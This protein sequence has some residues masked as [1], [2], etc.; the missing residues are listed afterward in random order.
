MR[1][2]GAQKLEFQVTGGFDM[3]SCLQHGEDME[4]QVAFPAL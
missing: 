2:F 3:L 1:I 4:P